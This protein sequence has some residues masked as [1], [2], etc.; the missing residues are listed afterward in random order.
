MQQPYYI[1]ATLENGVSGGSPIITY[2]VGVVIH[3]DPDRESKDACGV[4]IHLAKTLRAARKYVP[5]AK[6]FYFAIPGVILG[7][8]EHKVRCASCKIIKRLTPSDLAQLENDEMTDE[9]KL[10]KEIELRERYGQVYET[11]GLP[12]KVWFETHLNDYTD[13]DIANQGIEIFVDNKR[14]CGFK[15]VL[16][17]SKTRAVLRAVM[18]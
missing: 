11:G 15:P 7:E 17:R 2:K 5:V 10:K 12:G 8:D 18:A 16:S 14:R 6:E 1:K 13:E 4:G 3:P 9:E